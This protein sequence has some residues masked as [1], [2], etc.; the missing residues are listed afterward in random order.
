MTSK[1]LFPVQTKQ[2]KLE[3]SLGNNPSKRIPPEECSVIFRMLPHKG[4]SLSSEAL[5]KH[6]KH[7]RRDEQR[8]NKPTGMGTLSWKVKAL[9][10]L[11]MH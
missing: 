7:N 2:E 5:L 4:I 10:H 9:A 1:D 11:H 3:K 6:G 8:L